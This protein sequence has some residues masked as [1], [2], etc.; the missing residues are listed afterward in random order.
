MITE[1]NIRNCEHCDTPF[2]PKAQER[3]CCK[4]CQYVSQILHQGG[5]ERFYEL[6]G[7]QALPPV[8]SKVFQTAETDWLKDHQQDIESQS[9]TTNSVA[10]IKLQIEGISC[11]ACIWLIEAIFKQQN[12]G[13]NIQIDTR[14]NTLKLTWI[15]GSFELQKF[16]IELKKLGYTLSAHNS[17]QPHT[18]QSEQLTFKIGLCGFFLM[19]TMLF[20]LPSY[21][22]MQ[23]SYFLSPIFQLLS[24]LFATLSLIVGGGYFI[25]RA[26]TALKSKVLHIDFP[27]ALGLIV[28]YAGSIIGWATNYQNLVY[29]DFV[30]TFVFLMLLGRWLQQYAINRNQ[31]HLQQQDLGPKEVTILGGR[32][33]GKKIPVSE[34]KKGLHYSIAPGSINPVSAQLTDNAASL[35][36]EWINGEATPV[37]WEPQRPLPAGAINVGLN[38]LQCTANESWQNS[39][40]A[41]L[42]K[43]SQT[44]PHD[45]R[46]QTTLK[47]YIT[48]VLIIGMAGAYTWL[49]TT[50][51]PLQAAQVLISVLIVSCPCA[52][53]VALPLCDELAIT[54]LRRMGL[55][56]QTNNI[57]ERIR[58]INTVIFDKTGTLTMDAPR[59]KN[60]DTLQSL[61]PEA[62]TA[63]YNLVQDNLHPIARSLR[64]NLLAHHTELTHKTNTPL[65]TVNIKESIGK[66]VSWQDTDGNNWS[67]GK[68]N[69]TPLPHEQLTD[70]INSQATF[71]YNGVRIANFN[72][73]EDIREDA[74]QV[75]QDIQKQNMETVIISGDKSHHVHQIA[76]KLGLSPQNTHAECSPS[77]K[78][79]WI[80]NN[81]PNSALMI[82][83][84][85]NDSLAFNKAICRGTPV[86]DRSILKENADFFFFGRSLRSISSLFQIAQKRKKAVNTIFTCAIAY[87]ITAIT[88]CLAGQMHPLLAAI[89][90][91]LSSI[92]TLIIAWTGLTSK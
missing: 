58:K 80:Q 68:P 3:F 4:G 25:Q 81:A 73:E 27:I 53:G 29:F 83:D 65:P 64:E 47:L 54:R 60:V 55:F 43:P 45:Q 38:A 87:N 9:T 13:S 42:L 63:L 12:G 71:R 14:S 6:K 75:I 57:W 24:A 39:L 74:R 91:P 70:P 61:S 51:N 35:S 49:L 15:R 88:L 62:R 86:V 69:W 79:E 16:A 31:A 56:I 44:K 17:E 2:T 46:L 67:L 72:F 89:L 7:T 10:E 5:F 21:L 82:G 66:G 92:A 36:L 37:T 28:A 26:L 30:S 8:G 59:L 78:S 52:L 90:M 34:I 23:A 85:A 48:S 76:S 40:L 19:N 20:T 84:G 11:L 33:D 1:T 32:D 41:K 77:D 22:G 18:P 50:G